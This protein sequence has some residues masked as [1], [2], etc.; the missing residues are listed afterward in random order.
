MKSLSIPAT[1]PKNLHLYFGSQSGT[2]EKFCQT[3][4][5]EAKLLGCFESIKII[6][7]EDF[8]PSIFGI[9]KDTLTLI[10]VATH[11]EG[12]PCDNTAEFYK[13][14]KQAKKDN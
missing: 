5:E 7:F 3:L 14:L 8:Q 10:C 12:E 4:E 13:W 9:A 2:A 1:F 6:N 11:Y